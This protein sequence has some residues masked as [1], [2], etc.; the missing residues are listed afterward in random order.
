[1][2][3][4][5]R[6]KAA[7]WLSGL[8]L[9]LLTVVP[10]GTAR[11]SDACPNAAVR[12][13]FSSALARC[14]AYEW[15]SPAG[16]E[17]EFFFNDATET[18]SGLSTID[19]AAKEVQAAA[20]GD[21]FAY[22]TP[23]PPP[24]S[25]SDGEY[26]R[27]ARGPDGWSSEEM[28]PPQSTANS[29]ICGSGYVAVYSKD[30]TQ[31]LLADGVGQAGTK[32][33]Q[34]ARECGTDTPSLVPGEPQGFQ[35]LFVAEAESGPYQLVDAIEQAPA[36]FSPAGAWFE[37]ASEDLSHVVFTEAARLTAEA[38]AV[39]PS[40]ELSQGAP[41][42]PDVYEWAGG[43]VRL[44]TVLPSGAPAVGS[45]ADG[46]FPE[47]GGC[48]AGAAT[49]THAVSSDG[50]RV[51]FEAK[52]DLYLRLNAERPQSPVNGEERC[53]EP[54]DACTVQVDAASGG[55]E[56]GGGRFMR[57]TPDGSRVFFVDELRL[58]AD[59][60]AS[61]GAP[62]LYE[63]DTSAPLGE[64]LRDLT[65]HAGEPAD[66]LGVSGISDDGSYVY[67]VADAKLTGTENPVGATAV[68]GQPNLYLMHAG[69]IAFVATLDS[70]L[71]P[72]HPEQGTID[73]PDWESKLLTSRVTPDG[74]F[75]VFNS[76][77]PLTGYDNVDVRNG[78]R[79]DEIFLFDARHSTLVCASCSRTGAPSVGHA[80]ILPPSKDIV[81]TGFKVQG[82]L[83][84]QLANDG[85]VFFSTAESLLPA[86]GNGVSN[87]YEYDAG[88]LHLISTGTSGDPSYF[89][90]AS[91]DGSDVFVMTA[92]NLPSGE[93]AGEYRVYDAREGG[94]FPGP[95]APEACTEGCRGAVASPLA[96]PSPASMASLGSGN[97]VPS[98]PSVKKPTAAQLRRQRLARALA[99]C[100]KLRQRHRRAACRARARRMFDAKKS[101]RRA[102]KG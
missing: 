84:R 61:S 92:Q 31:D 10:A 79:D 14:R 83:Q 97:V 89:Y 63:Y 71:S 50:S 101:S 93:P 74:A 75:M 69:T 67:F 44:V 39:E 87:A 24:G 8:G 46:V 23:Y 49:F 77:L 53:T 72:R 21:R 100:R 73:S 56:S 98:S 35:N 20:E 48:C 40:A 76:D 11:G 96:F 78:V 38:P 47:E 41:P 9:L 19:G 57:A 66:V 91:T 60:T 45:L 70:A 37:G 42:L 36:G 22:V 4:V 64:R 7:R 6:R 28:I 86:A 99:R 30:L 80:E 81:G 51:L 5:R 34:G 55:G 27:A 13:G 58:T 25:P 52:G 94:G 88:A 17:P 59:A 29:V 54:A 32:I 68:A 26:L 43:T 1:V 2:G 12:T 82:Y 102:R 65:A 95:R 85:R 33:G 3:T 90:D 18:G 62:D 16:S 15:V